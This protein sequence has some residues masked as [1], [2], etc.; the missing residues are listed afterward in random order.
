MCLSNTIR[1][2]QRGEILLKLLNERKSFALV[3]FLLSKIDSVCLLI[4][5]SQDTYSTHK[6]R[7]MEINFCYLFS[8]YDLLFTVVQGKE[9]GQNFSCRGFTRSTHF[10]VP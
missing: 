7:S 9:S 3:T 4:I 2:Q 1:R 10:K 6:L 5:T 8:I